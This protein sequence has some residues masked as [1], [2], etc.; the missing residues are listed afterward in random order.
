MAA[1]RKAKKKSKARTTRITV[2]N[3]KEMAKS[4]A[5]FKALLKNAQKRKIGIGILNAPFKLHRAEA[6]S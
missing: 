2:V 4:P 5:K 6:V 3:L 1:K